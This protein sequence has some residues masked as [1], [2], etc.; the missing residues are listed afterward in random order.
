MTV[1]EDIKKNGLRVMRLTATN[2]K[3]LALVEIT[4]KGAV[5]TVKGPNG[6]GKSTVLD[7]L[8][9]ALGGANASPD[10]PIKKGQDKAEVEVDLGT[11]IVRRRWSAS[12]TSLEITWNGEAVKQPQSLLDEFV[13]KA[14]IDVGRFLALDEGAKKDILKSIVDLGID[15]EKH[16]ERREKIF[17]DRTIV[18]RDEKKARAHYNS[19]DGD[20]T[21]P[22]KGETATALMEKFEAAKDDTQ[23]NKEKRRQLQSSFDGLDNVTQEIVELEDQLTDAKERKKSYSEE[24]ESLKK[25]V[26]KLVDP[27]IEAIQEKVRTVDAKNKKVRQNQDKKKALTE[28]DE[29]ATESKRLTRRIEKMDEEKATALANAK[30]PVKGLSWTEDAIVFDGLPFSQA[31]QSKQLQI[32]VAISTKANPALKVITIKDASLFDRNSIEEIR[33]IAEKEKVTV[34]LEIVSNSSNGKLTIEEG[35]E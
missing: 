18:N 31:S 13:K 3:K 4:P 16:E 11:I 8:F 25:S 12:G 7:A 35:G 6:A 17:D 20:E 14:T 15:L 29:H 21:G 1:R 28:A 5:V 34:F 32:A 27:D 30:F 24:V 2:F 26:A 10:V 22:L 23:A 9:A 19:I 33:E